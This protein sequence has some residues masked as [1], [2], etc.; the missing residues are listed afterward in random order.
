MRALIMLSKVSNSLSCFVHEPGLASNLQEQGM[1]SLIQLPVV[2]RPADF[3][4]WHHTREFLREVSACAI[5]IRWMRQ[6]RTTPAATTLEPRQQNNI[7]DFTGKTV[8]HSA[9]LR[10]AAKHLVIVVVDERKAGT[11]PGYHISNWFT[12][13]IIEIQCR[14]EKKVKLLA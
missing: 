14:P 9:Y 7:H 2:E 8:V 6:E 5:E 1:H 3:A 4:P 10:G 13:P 11:G 12:P